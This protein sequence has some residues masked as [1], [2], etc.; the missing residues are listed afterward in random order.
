LAAGFA[1]AGGGGAFGGGAA[2]AG[3]AAGDVVTKIGSTPV[4]SAD[5]L[6]AAVRSAT[7]GSKITVTYTRGS[8]TRTATVTLG[9]A[10]SK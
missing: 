6:I 10:V 2:G 1:G 7:P 9:S 5:A 8:D 3:L 4:D